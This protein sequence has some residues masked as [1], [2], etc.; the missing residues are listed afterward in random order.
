MGSKVMIAIAALSMAGAAS[1]K[2]PTRVELNHTSWGKPGVSFEA[3]RIDAGMCTYE[4][5][6]K[7]VSG[8][9]AAKTMVR[10]SRT[11]DG[12]TNAIEHSTGAWVGSDVLSMKRLELTY[13]IDK[14]FDEIRDVQYQALRSCLIDRGYTPFRLT[15]DQARHLS[16]FD[17]RDMDRQRYLYRLGSDASILNAQAIRAEELQ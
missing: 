12:A 2:V 8:T 5:M 16:R 10:A 13:R 9:P 7:D 1:A 6:R 3:Y 4:A 17:H 15:D 11:L 14:Q